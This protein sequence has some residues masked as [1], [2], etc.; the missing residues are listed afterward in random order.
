[1]F[2]YFQRIDDGTFKD[3]VNYEVDGNTLKIKNHEFVTVNEKWCNLNLMKLHHIF[4]NTSF[5][6]LNSL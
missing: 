6:K 1:M 2:E 4:K 3:N 5:C